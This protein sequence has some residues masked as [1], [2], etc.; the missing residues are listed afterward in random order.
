MGDE[1][2]RSIVHIIRK[3]CGLDS[4]GMWSR[5][6]AMISKVSDH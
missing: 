2:A 3:V 5:L 6:G 4:E 1:G